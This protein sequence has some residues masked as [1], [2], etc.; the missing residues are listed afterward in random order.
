M[1]LSAVANH[2]HRER[3]ADRQRER[4]ATGNWSGPGFRQVPE[5][6]QTQEDEGLPAPRYRH[7]A[8]TPSMV[9]LPSSSSSSG[10]S[11]SVGKLTAATLDTSKQLEE[12]VRIPHRQ[13]GDAVAAHGRRRRA[14][15]GVEAA[16]GAVARQRPAAEALRHAGLTGQVRAV[17]HLRPVGRVVAAGEG[18]R[19]GVDAVLQIF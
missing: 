7:C 15:A 6:F 14:A 13:R 17:A 1:R 10:S 18:A 11:V 12:E 9:R 5:L 19:R 4:I 8:P 2:K 3:T 16:A